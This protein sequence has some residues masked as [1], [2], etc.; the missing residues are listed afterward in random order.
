VKYVLTSDADHLCRSKVLYH[1]VII[2]KKS[3]LIENAIRG[4][5]EAC[6]NIYNSA[7]QLL[8]IN[9]TCE[10]K[11]SDIMQRKGA[12]LGDNV[13]LIGITPVDL[14]WCTVTPLTEFYVV[15]A[16]VIFLQKYGSI[17][18]I[19]NA[20]IFHTPSEQRQLLGV[21][22]NYHLYFVQVHKL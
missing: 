14:K 5:I 20:S 9:A 12:V 3:G 18:V 21:Y 13:K 16:E 6:D 2:E 4:M 8:L 15:C 10:E 17:R 11:L 22:L 19:S 7:R 1:D